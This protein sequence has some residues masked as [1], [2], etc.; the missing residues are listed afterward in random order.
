VDPANPSAPGIELVR[1][2]TPFGGPEHIEQDV[3][4]IFNFIGAGK[5]TFVV[6]IPTYSDAQ[7]QVS[8][9]NGGWNVSAHLEVT[10]GT[11]PRRVLA[12]QSL[13][14]DSFDASKSGETISLPF[15][16]PP[17]TT[18]TTIEYRVTGH[19]G[20]TDTTGDCIGPADEFCKRTHTLTV[21]GQPLGTFVPWRSDCAKLCTQT[22]NDAGV[23]PAGSYCAQNPCGAIS[24]VRAPRANWCPSSE[25]PPFTFTPDLAP[26][27]HT[28]A[29]SIA[30]IVGDWRVS[31]SVIAYGD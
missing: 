31:A 20:A 3:T 30:T 18:Q 17:G 7:G 24:S 4:D 2:I 14:Y 13:V 25:T 29:F 16:L 28:F 8:G 26:G 21:D 9:S 23:G 11:P 12:V 1:A 5:R 19:G 10:P 6:T 15:T 22:V 27:D